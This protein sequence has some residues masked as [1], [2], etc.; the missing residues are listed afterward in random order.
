MCSLFSPVCEEEFIY[1]HVRYILPYTQ[2]ARKHNFYR[3]LEDIWNKLPSWGDEKLVWNSVE[4]NFSVKIASSAICNR[5]S[6]STFQ[7]FF[8]LLIWMKCSHLR[9]SDTNVEVRMKW[10]NKVSAI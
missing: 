7:N 6:D 4:G 1:L 10:N 9:T 5:V 2:S 8:I 3:I